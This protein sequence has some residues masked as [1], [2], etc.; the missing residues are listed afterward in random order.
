MCVCVCVCVRARARIVG[1]IISYQLTKYTIF[2][3]S[4]GPVIV[5]VFPDPVCPK[6][7]AVHEYLTRET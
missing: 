5:C 1:A 3:S 7:K 6:A 2:T 4:G